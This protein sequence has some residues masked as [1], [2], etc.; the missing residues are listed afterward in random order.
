MKPSLHVLVLVS[1]A[2]LAPVSA[3]RAEGDG[4]EQPKAPGKE[5]GKEGGKEQGK[6]GQKEPGREPGKDKDRGDKRGE[7]GVPAMPEDKEEVAKLAEE[8]FARADKNSDGYVKGAELVQAW[9][10]RF[11]RNGDGAV[12]KTEFTE[13][14]ARPPRLR[15]LH[16]MRDPRARAAD[17]T[18]TFDQDKNGTVERAEYPGAEGVF[19]KADRNKDG[20][21]QPGEMLA[22]AEDEIDEIRKQ[23]KDPN[24]Y[25]FLLIFDITKDNN[26]TADEYDGSSVVFRKFD[27]DNDGTVTYYELYPERMNRMREEEKQPE[28]ENKNAIA[29]LDKDKDGKVAR[30]EFPGSDAAWARMDTNGDGFVTSADK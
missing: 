15:R 3:A 28:P 27:D 13:I 11:D 2:L 29:T 20:A 9:A 1:F 23:M 12:S 21:L 6:D 10:D 16:P 25:E 30:A 19:K 18:R 22:L 7:D 14:M 26:V 4:K 5:S 8:Q 24:R 17:S